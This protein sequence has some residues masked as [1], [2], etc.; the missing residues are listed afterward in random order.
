MEAQACSAACRSQGLSGLKLRVWLPLLSLLR[1]VTDHSGYVCVCARTYAR[2][3]ARLEWSEVFNY[4]RSVC[5]IRFVLVR[6]V[7]C[8]GFKYVV[9]MCRTRRKHCR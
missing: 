5:E 6:L 4:T 7:R 3:H 1:L 8:A 9:N 2:T